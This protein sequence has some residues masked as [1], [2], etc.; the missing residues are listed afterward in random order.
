MNATEYKKRALGVERQ[1]HAPVVARMAE[2]GMSRLL[3]GMFGIC[4]ESGEIAD[5]YKRVVFYGKPLDP[6]NLKEELGDVMWYIAIT[7]DQLGITIEDV[8][9]AN[10]AKLEKRYEGGFTENKA[11]N[12]D[13]EAERTILEG[14]DG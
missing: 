8:M 3:H 12:R 7:C 11:V 9:A 13:L 10:I 4:S 2:P 6:V 14:K 5:H 1:D